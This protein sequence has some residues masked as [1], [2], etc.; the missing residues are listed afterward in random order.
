MLQRRRE[1]V[2]HQIVGEMFHREIDDLAEQ[3]VGAVAEDRADR[4]LIVRILRAA[5]RA[6]H[7]RRAC[8]GS[9][10]SRP[11]CRRASARRSRRKPSACACTVT[12]VPPRCSSNV[13]VLWPSSMRLP[14]GR[15][16]N[17][18]NTMRS[19]GL[20]SWKIPPIGCDV[21][22]RRAHVNEDLAARPRVRLAHRIGEAVRSPPCGEMLCVGE[23]AEHQRARRRENPR[24][25]D[26]A[27]RR[28]A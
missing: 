24:H 11:P 27:R 5:S 23:H 7:G 16:T 2:G 21:A 26:L 3:R 1:I 6:P 19:C 14:S 10:T 25:G 18:V 20:I 22:V 15:S 9:A 8:R 12:F 28:P 17:D 13:T 4:L